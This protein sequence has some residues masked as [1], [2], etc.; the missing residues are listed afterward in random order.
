[1]GKYRI[2][3][4]IICIGWVFNVN[5][6]SKEPDIIDK[7]NA[8]FFAPLNLFDIINPNFQ[9]GYERMINPKFAIQLE[10]AY[11]INH[12][13]I[14]YLI[15]AVNDVKDCQQTN[16]GFKI[17]GEVKYFISKRKKVKPYVSGE[18]FY[19]HN[20]STVV[21]TFLISDTTFIYSEPRPIGH[22]GYDDLFRNEKHRYG[23]NIKFGLKILMGKSL[24]FE[25]HI[26]LGIVYR[27]SKQSDRENMNDK[28]YS[29]V[30]SF[31]NK[32]GN[33]WIPNFPLNLKLGYR[34]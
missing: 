29:E 4:I 13:V 34:F 23:M 2:L 24:L 28:L 12:S 9:I 6:Q 10:G 18:L 22:N 27:K 8:V 5:G 11:I 20:N 26:G 25:P 16:S 31:H 14:D 33:M 3:T 19:L 15:D 30:S 32:A 21:E 17:R 7:P 1:M